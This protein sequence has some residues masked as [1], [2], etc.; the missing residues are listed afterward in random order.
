MQEN[1]QSECPRCHGI[2][3]KK[4]RHCR[5]CSD[6]VGLA[7]ENAPKRFESYIEK[8]D[9]CW[10][11]KGTKNK[12]WGYGQFVVHGKLFRAHR[13]SYELYVGP[14]KDGLCVCH[15]CDNRLCVNPAHLWLGTQKEN[16]VDAVRKGRMLRGVRNSMARFSEEEIKMIREL[17]RQGIYQKHIAEEFGTSQSYI[18]E[19]VLN[20]KWAWLT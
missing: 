12:V 9:G 13:Y 5:E 8:T 10:I 2:K 4:A 3:H 14:I 11:Y 16:I 20:K 19:I 7:L 15:S 18:S 17:S 6:S 1:E